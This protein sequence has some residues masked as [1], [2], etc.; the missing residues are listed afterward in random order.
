LSIGRELRTNIFFHD[1]LP[2]IASRAPL[3]ADGH[4]MHREVGH[5]PRIHAERPPQDLAR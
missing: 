5:I 1:F 4:L 3:D 2:G